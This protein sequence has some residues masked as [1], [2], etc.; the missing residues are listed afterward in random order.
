MNARSNKQLLDYKPLKSWMDF[1]RALSLLDS[2]RKGDAF[3]L[4]C[5]Y[6]FLLHPKNE[7]INR[8]KVWLLSEVPVAVKKELSIGEDTGFD[9][10]LQDK[11]NGG[12]ILQRLT[13]FGLN[14]LRGASIS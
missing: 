13:P 6:Y 9:L 4:L 11:A 8:E 2:K 12:F 3:E 7:H 5:K 1:N 10:L 14:N